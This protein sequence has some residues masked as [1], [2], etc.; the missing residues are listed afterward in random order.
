MDSS[1]LRFVFGDHGAP[2]IVGIF[3]YA[4]KFGIYRPFSLPFQPLRV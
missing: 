1:L 4:S 2:Y 3:G